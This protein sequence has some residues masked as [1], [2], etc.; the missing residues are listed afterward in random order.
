MEQ[1]QLQPKKQLKKLPKLRPKQKVF[2]NEFARTGNGTQAALKA[3]EIESPNKI[4]VAKSIA[5][6][7]LTKP[8]IIE[9]VE[10]TQVTLRDAL[11]KQGV[12]PQKFA[13]KVD[14]LLENPNY[15]SVDAGLRHASNVFGVED[16]EK[17]KMQMNYN[18]FFSPDLRKKVQTMEA[19]IKQALSDV[20]ET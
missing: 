7:N 6:E 8:Y 10:I 5:S 16:G 2:V 12:T 9:A 17:P 19:E 15:K 20:T 1:N 18:F 4:D 11:I 3:Y 13:I 14:E